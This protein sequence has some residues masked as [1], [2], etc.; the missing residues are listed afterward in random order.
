MV[1]A[2]RDD[3]LDLGVA[4]Q[5]TIN[6]TTRQEAAVISMQINGL[7]TAFSKAREETAKKELEGKP[8]D[9]KGSLTVANIVTASGPETL[10][11]ALALAKA[12][13][14]QPPDPIATS[15]AA[16]DTVAGLLKMAGS[17]SASAGP[18]GAAFSAVF[19]MISMILNFF[20]PEPEDLKKEF[21]KILRNVKSEDTLHTA[22]AGFES[23]VTFANGWRKLV[24]ELDAEGKPAFDPNANPKPSELK[25]QIEKLNLVEGN[26]AFSL[27]VVRAWLEEP[28]NQDLDKW[29]EVFKVLCDA[30]LQLFLIVAKQCIYARDIE[31]YKKYL[32]PNLRQTDEELGKD[33]T[34]LLHGDKVA[35]AEKKNRPSEFYVWDELENAAH[36][37]ETNLASEKARLAEF[38]TTILPVARKWGTYVMA[39][40]NSNM[41][42]TNRPICFKENKWAGVRNACKRITIGAP[43]GG[44]ATPD[45][46]YEAWIVDSNSQI[47]LGLLKPKSREY[48][49]AEELIVGSENPDIR[50]ICPA[51]G[52]GADGNYTLYACAMVDAPNGGPVFT[53]RKWNRAPFMTQGD[54]TGWIVAT[55]F[56]MHVSQVR[57][58]TPKFFPDDVDR[59]PQEVATRIQNGASIVYGKIDGAKHLAVGLSDLGGTVMLARVPLWYGEDRPDDRIDGISVDPYVLWAYENRKYPACATHAS[60][61]KAV[62]GGNGLPRWLGQ[63]HPVNVEV[64]EPRALAVCEDGTLFVLTGWANLTA[65]Y[66]IDFAQAAAGNPN[67]ALVMGKWERLPHSPGGDMAW[68]VPV[69]GWPQI[70]SLMDAVGKRTDFVS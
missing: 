41:L 67:G 1:Q 56:P 17:L 51:P 30:Y 39:W 45:T 37:K 32:G 40:S 68:K 9:V 33:W 54:G 47:R 64:R 8:L 3:L 69:F 49:H 38:L 70:Q 18:Y 44:I 4:L 19:S 10:K 60:V 12:L 2:T 35:E 16:M 63:N 52:T 53:R 14:K 48:G 58:V 23:I 15:A 59:V 20:A 7:R 5:T 24:G 6:E 28:N 66:A 36:V 21:Q 34:E 29:P 22:K 61:L 27:R 26:V 31:K 55:P 65:S 25:T 46:P 50:D 57:V 62:F 13:G 11:G 42:V 43:A